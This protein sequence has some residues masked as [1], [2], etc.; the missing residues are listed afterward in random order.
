MEWLG[1]VALPEADRRRLDQLLEVYAFLHDEV[2]R[3]DADVRR[4][5]K[6]D[7]RCQHR[8]T[9]PGIGDFFAALIMAEVDDI[10]RFPNGSLV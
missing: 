8:A 2:R 3:S 9:I 10:R 1:K 7:V 5:V 6:A 4:M